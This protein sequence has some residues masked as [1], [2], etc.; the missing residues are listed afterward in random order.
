MVAAWDEVPGANDS[1]EVPALGKLH[2]NALIGAL[3]CSDDASHW[4]CLS[5]NNPADVQG[6]Q[7]CSLIPYLPMPRRGIISSLVIAAQV[8]GRCRR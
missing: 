8:C 6:A 2:V 1:R 3:K 7:R 5:P 4:I